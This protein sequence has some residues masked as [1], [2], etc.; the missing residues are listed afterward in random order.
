MLVFGYCQTF[1]QIK[2]RKPTLQIGSTIRIVVNERIELVGGCN[3]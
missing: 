3:Y 2:Y 1:D